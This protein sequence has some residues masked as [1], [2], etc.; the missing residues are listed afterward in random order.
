MN[1]V[2]DLRKKAGI[3][4]IDLAEKIGMN[5]GNLSKLENHNEYMTVQNAHSLASFF[6]VSID[7]LLGF[8]NIANPKDHQL[9]YFAN[10]AQLVTLEDIVLLYKHERITIRFFSDYIKVTF[11]DQNKPEVIY[12]RVNLSEER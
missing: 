9:K 4:Q 10:T 3:K 1:R 11:D 6:D 12:N 2:K 5:R 8:S 7:Y